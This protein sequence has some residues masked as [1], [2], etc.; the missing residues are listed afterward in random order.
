MCKSHRL[1][2]YERDIQNFKIFKLSENIQKN[3][4]I[5]WVIEDIELIQ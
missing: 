1:G 4:L 3:Q 5:G 2:F